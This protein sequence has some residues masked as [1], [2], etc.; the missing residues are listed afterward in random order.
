MNY[1]IN[2]MKGLGDNIFQRHI[3]KALLNSRN[4]VWI[5]T[6]WPELY[7]DLSVHFVRVETSLRTQKKNMEK[8]ATDWVSSYPSDCMVINPAYGARDLEKGSIIR[9]MESKAGFKLDIT[10]FGLSSY[11]GLPC[12]IKNN[13]RP[14]AV[15][16]PVTVRREWENTARAPL[17]KYIEE[18]SLE[19]KRRGYWVVSVADL[20]GDNEWL[21][22]SEPYADQKFYKGELGISDLMGL[23]EGS[24]VVVGGVGWIVP[25]CIALETPLFCILGGQGGHNAP[26]IITDTRMNL[27][28]IRFATPDKFCRCTDMKHQCEKVISN[29]LFSFTRFLN[30]YESSTSIDV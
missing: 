13:G 22:G 16:R 20:D 8:S 17:P 7:R 6:P 21:V 14:V 3:V 12:Q 1:Y 19:L 18:A 9:A 10:D 2:S 5:S 4:E 29:M 24:A 28:M 25:A 27:S 15:I 11:G 30:Y 23:I 26:G